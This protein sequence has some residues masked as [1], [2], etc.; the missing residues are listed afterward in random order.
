MHCKACDNVLTPAEDGA[1]F[2]VSNSRVDLCRRCRSD[3]PS[4]LEIVDVRGNKELD[5]EPDN[6]LLPWNEEGSY[7]EGYPDDDATEESDWYEDGWE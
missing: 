2:V 6:N 4:D 5:T 3:L 7:E 1:R